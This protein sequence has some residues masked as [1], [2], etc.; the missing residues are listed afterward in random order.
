MFINK[1]YEIKE[2]VYNDSKDNQQKVNNKNLFNIEAE[3]KEFKSKVELDI[4]QYNRELLNI[5]NNS[6]VEQTDTIKSMLS[7]NFQSNNVFNSKKNKDNSEYLD[8][9]MANSDS[10]IEEKIEDIFKIDDVKNQITKKHAFALFTI[11]RD[12]VNHSIVKKLNEEGAIEN[13]F[14]VVKNA[15]ILINENEGKYIGL[16]ALE[17]IFQMPIIR[18]I[19]YGKKIYSKED[20]IDSVNEISNKE[21]SFNKRYDKNKAI[22][23]FQLDIYW[24]EIINILNRIE[25]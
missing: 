7:N 17:N 22:M 19:I 25:L 11:L 18:K 23:D 15:Q 5:I 10:V 16:E 24:S 2:S 20:W 4:K 3:F 21:G 13:E 8:E 12:K 6:F 1:S 9:N 14:E